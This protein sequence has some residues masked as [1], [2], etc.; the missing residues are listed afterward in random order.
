MRKLIIGLSILFFTLSG[1]IK[2]KELEIPV[3]NSIYQV[4]QQEIKP[5]DN[6]QKV[7]YI[8]GKFAK[9]QAANRASVEELQTTIT[10]LENSLTNKNE[11]SRAKVRELQATIAKLEAILTNKNERAQTNVKTKG[12]DR[13][14][15]VLAVLGDGAFYSGQVVINDNLTNAVKELVPDIMES[16]DNRVIIEGHSDNIPIKSTAD[17]YGDNLEL[18]FLRAKAVALILEKNGISLERISVMGYGDTRPIA[19]N[20]TAEGKAKN[21]R[22]EIKLSPENKEF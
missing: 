22:V 1:Y 7:E 12:S 19:S 5:E 9:E 2:I 14:T 16:P 20:E 17:L 8:L 10:R 11:E 3:K 18:S 21:R 15:R 4:A 6:S 13:N